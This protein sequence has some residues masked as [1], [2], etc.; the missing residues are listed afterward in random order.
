MTGKAKRIGILAEKANNEVTQ[1]RAS[2]VTRLQ[3]ELRIR[4]RRD[5]CSTFLRNSRECGT[6]IPVVI[7]VI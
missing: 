7:E 1:G 3:R 2:R 4:D 6:A 5:A